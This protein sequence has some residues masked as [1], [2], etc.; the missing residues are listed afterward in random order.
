MKGFIQVKDN[1]NAIY[2]S[3][4]QFEGTS[5]EISFWQKT[6]IFEKYEALRDG[7]NTIARKK[8]MNINYLKG[9]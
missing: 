5:R 2:D 8:I 3:I 4:K 6:I 1:S 7:N 9:Y